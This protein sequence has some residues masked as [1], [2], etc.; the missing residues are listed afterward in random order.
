MSNAAEDEQKRVAVTLLK[1]QADT[2]RVEAGKAGIG[3]GLLSRA[4]VAYG[5]AHIDDSGIQA[6]I[7]E[8]KEAD[9]ERRAAVGKKAMRSRW[10]DKSDREN[11]E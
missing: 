11:S 9:R 3:P 4:L 8:V 1:S 5:L 2:L 6:A 10:G 7:E